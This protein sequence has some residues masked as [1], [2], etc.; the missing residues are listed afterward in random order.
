MAATIVRTPADP[1]DNALDAALEM[2]FPASDPVA[3]FVPGQEDPA[4]VQAKQPMRTLAAVA[5]TALV[6]AACNEIPQDAS[7]PFAGPAETK[8][9][10]APPFGGDKNSYEEAL[11]KRAAT[12]NEYV[13][14]GDVNK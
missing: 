12:Q 10:M 9:Y 6:L 1:V 3:V 13:Q 14:F 7:K 11:A 5:S 2:T 4:A 8:S